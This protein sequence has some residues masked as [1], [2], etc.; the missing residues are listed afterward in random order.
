MFVERIGRWLARAAADGLHLSDQP[1]EPLL[2]ARER[3]IVDPMLFEGSSDGA[4]LPL[5]VGAL[6][7][8]PPVLEVIRLPEGIDLSKVNERVRF[9]ALPLAG[10]PWHVA[11]DSFATEGFPGAPAP[12]STHRHGLGR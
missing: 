5:M 12:S 9:V 1:L 11:D 3:I 4:P 6:S 8:D 7:D 2:I 10:P